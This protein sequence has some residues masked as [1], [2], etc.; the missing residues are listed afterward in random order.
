MTKGRLITL[1]LMFK[2]YSPNKP[3]K[4]NNTPLRTRLLNKIGA[5][6][7]INRFQKISIKIRY[8]KAMAMLLVAIKK[9]NYLSPFKSFSTLIS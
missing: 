3:T 2:I 7:F 6:P 4:N 9:P 5:V 1:A 8:T